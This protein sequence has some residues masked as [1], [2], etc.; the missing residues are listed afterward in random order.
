M[1]T[2]I[3]MFT[4]IHGKTFSISEPI[5]FHSSIAL[6]KFSKLQNVAVPTMELPVSIKL[7]TN[8]YDLNNSSLRIIDTQFPILISDTAK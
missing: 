5:P 8:F 1:C 7:I 6:Q 4:H 3:L 2:I